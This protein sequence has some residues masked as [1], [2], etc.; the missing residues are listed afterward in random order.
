MLVGTGQIKQAPFIWNSFLKPVAYV[1]KVGPK[2]IWNK[3]Q[4]ALFTSGLSQFELQLSVRLIRQRTVCLDRSKELPE[5]GVETYKQS[6]EG[7][8]GQCH[9]WTP[10]RILKIIKLNTFLLQ[11]STGDVRTQEDGLLR[12]GLQAAIPYPLPLLYCIEF[13]LYDDKV[14][15]TQ[16]L[17]SFS[18]S[19]K[20]SLHHGLPGW[21]AVSNSFAYVP[22]EYSAWL[23]NSRVRPL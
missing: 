21:R 23:Y 15:Q 5:E 8:K 22:A 12:V 3:E 2:L 13:L 19:F 16:F 10:I 6:V 14:R 4:E 20:S 18:I 9:R 11:G 1:V 7:L 17:G